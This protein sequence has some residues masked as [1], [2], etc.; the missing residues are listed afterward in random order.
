LK[1]NRLLKKR[2]GTNIHNWHFSLK[3][4]YALKDYQAFLQELAQM[5]VDIKE[6]DFT[7][8]QEIA[9]FLQ[10]LEFPDKQEILKLLL[11]T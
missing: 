9:G 2:F 6:L 5:P 1:Y 4:L 8:K 11:T 10:K 3:L 7:R